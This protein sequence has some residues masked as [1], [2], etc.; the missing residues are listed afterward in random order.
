MKKYI[1]IVTCILAAIACQKQKPTPR[2][3]IMSNSSTEIS[4]RSNANK[5]IVPFKRTSTGLAEVQVSLNGVPFNMWWDT[6]ASITSISTLELA[7]LVKEGKIDEDDYIQTIKSRIADGSQ[8]EEEVYLIKELYIKGE[9][10]KYLT[11]YNILATVSD[12]LSAP[13]LIGQNV[14][15]QLP[16]HSFNESRSVIEFDTY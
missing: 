3:Q 5:V 12:N 9:E 15:Q 6:G 2:Q 7:K 8:V 14:I 1:L 11:I 13:L 10:G 4:V 16:K